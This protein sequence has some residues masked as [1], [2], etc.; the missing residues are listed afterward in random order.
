MRYRE[1]LTPPVTWWLLAGLFAL[2]CGTAV[3]AYAGLPWGIGV[4]LGVALAAAGGLAAAAVRIEVSD[5]ELVAGRARIERRYLARVTP[6]DADATRRRAGPEADAR[7]YLLLRPYVTTSVEVRLDDPD[8]P[9][10]YWLVGTR[11]PDRLAAVLAEAGST[12]LTP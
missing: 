5:A 1:R 9:V 11:R 8:D 7:A 2:S 12:R 10:P 3:G 4:L 6:L